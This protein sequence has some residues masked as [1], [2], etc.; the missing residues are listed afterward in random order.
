[1]H[2]TF[3]PL[4]GSIHGVDSRPGLWTGVRRGSR[5]KTSQSGARRHARA[6]AKTR[7][8]S[9]QRQ[10]S[11]AYTNMFSYRNP[12]IP[13]A[14]H[15]LLSPSRVEARRRSTQSGGPGERRSE[16]HRVKGGVV[17][18]SSGL[19]V[20]R[21]HVR[22]SGGRRSQGGEAAVRAARAGWH[23]LVEFRADFFPLLQNCIC[24]V[25]RQHRCQLAPFNLRHSAH[26]SPT[27]TARDDHQ[28]E[29]DSQS[30]ARRLLVLKL[31]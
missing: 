2:V 30:H 21:W 27:P 23:E 11:R 10:H 5:R 15:T 7:R 25:R 4:S 28:D 17:Y 19:V 22:R 8:L 9:I 1:M 26:G 24:L 18:M 31:R 12:D 13:P 14:T 3:W 16:L 29:P 6:R 20:V